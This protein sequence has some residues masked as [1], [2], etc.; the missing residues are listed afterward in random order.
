MMMG[1]LAPILL[2]AAGA[3]FQTIPAVPPQE[4][5]EYVLMGIS[6]RPDRCNLSLATKVELRAFV[7]EPQRWTGKCV[8]VDGYWQHNALF[9]ARRDARKRY[10]QS[11]KALSTRR[12]GIYGTERL[13]SSAPRTAH[14]HTA[15]GFAGQCET[16]G[17]GAI[18]VMGYCHYTSGPYIAVAEMRRR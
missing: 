7:S 6:A 16:L 5:E 11:N 3:A 4:A 15:V 2:I 8:A 18:M 14:L 12:V 10:A 13:L 9:A 1:N 17:E